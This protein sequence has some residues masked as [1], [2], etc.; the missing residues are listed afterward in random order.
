MK[1]FLRFTNGMFE[2][3]GVRG[4]D[5]L[6][7]DVDGRWMYFCTSFDKEGQFT[8][9]RYEEITDKV[10]DEILDRITVAINDCTRS[11]CVVD[12]RDMDVEVFIT[13]FNVGS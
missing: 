2:F 12:C 8:S 4:T 9:K 5:W 7:Y 6:G 13:G 3:K 11:A 1:I 10:R